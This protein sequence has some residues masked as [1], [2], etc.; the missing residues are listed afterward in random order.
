MLF[1]CTDRCRNNK[2][3]CH[4]WPECGGYKIFLEDGWCMGKLVVGP[5]CGHRLVRARD[6][7]NV[8][9]F[10]REHV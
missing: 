1:L 2:E 8:V 9:V 5:F 4:R 6:E 7:G 3:R 10:F